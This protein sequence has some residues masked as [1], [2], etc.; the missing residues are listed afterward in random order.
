MNFFLAQCSFN[1]ASN[2]LNVNRFDRATFLNQTHVISG[3]RCLRRGGNERAATGGEV[4]RGRAHQLVSIF[5]TSLFKG[6]EVAN[7]ISILRTPPES[8][9]PQ[10]V[11]AIDSANS[12]S[13]KNLIKQQAFIRANTINQWTVSGGKFSHFPTAGKW[14]NYSVAYQ[15]LVFPRLITIEWVGAADIPAESCDQTLSGARVEKVSSESVN[16][17]CTAKN[18]SQFERNQ[19]VSE[20][21]KGSL[22]RMS[23]CQPWSTLSLAEE[24]CLLFLSA[25]K[26]CWHTCSACLIGKFIARWVLGS[27]RS[28]ITL[29]CNV[30]QRFDALTT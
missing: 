19:L 10:T 28:D 30:K 29:S 7:L 9:D 20:A 2:Y 1:E 16:Q 11:G 22:E 14:K 26:T 25:P 21:A 18:S 23:Q 15:S 24:L 13:T 8:L 4:F 6:N 17:V 3:S 27:K 5:A 12:E